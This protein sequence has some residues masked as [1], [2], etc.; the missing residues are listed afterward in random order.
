M[1]ARTDTRKDMVRAGARLLAANGYEA[2]ALLDVVEAA[3]ASRGSIYFHF[4]GGKREL[5]LESLTY[6]TGRAL[7][8]SA[9]AIQHST[10]T[11]EVIRRTGDVLA[12]SL[13]SSGFEMGCPV[14]TVALETAN[15]DEAIR[16]LSADFFASWRSLY[17]G[18]LLRDGFDPD[19][20]QRLATLIVAV[21]EGGLLLART[22]RSAQPL[23][24][25]CAE[26]AELVGAAS[27]S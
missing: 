1:G 27:P 17:V 11:S 7:E 24:D 9:G 3:G 21:F 19:R 16:S 2:T 15:T 8:R 20:A 13:E 10:T 22:M 18:S 5:A 6:S 4:P 12:K 23:H 25:A 14:A 26:A